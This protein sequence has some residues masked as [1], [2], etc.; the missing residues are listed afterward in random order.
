[1]WTRILTIFLR[2]IS[3]PWPRSRFMMVSFTLFLVGCRD[4]CLL[5][6]LL[7][8]HIS[9]CFPRLYL[10]PAHELQCGSSRH[11]NLTSF[12]HLEASTLSQG[13]KADLFS[14]QD[15]WLDLPWLTSAMPT[16]K[17]ANICTTDGESVS[18]LVSCVC[19]ILMQ[20]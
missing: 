13:Q 1:V 10:G 6:L 18:W 2:L 14:L 3:L 15:R 20:I 19:S 5:L 12:I 8:A 4:C 16:C 11:P 17:H 7:L 9:L